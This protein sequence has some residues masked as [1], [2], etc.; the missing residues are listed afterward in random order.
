MTRDEI[1]ALLARCEAARTKRDAAALAKEH[2]EHCVMESPTAGGTVSGRDEIQ[3]VYATWYTAFPDMVTTTEPP[4]IDGHRVAQTLVLTGTDA[5][6]FLGL[7]P[8]N[9]PFRLPL[10]W[11]IDVEDGAIVRSRPIYDFSGMLIQI[12]VLRVKP[13]P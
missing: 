9:K 2:A 10:V 6:G 7:P 12:G 1:V 8:T 4:I 13:S 3:R 5:G 11:L